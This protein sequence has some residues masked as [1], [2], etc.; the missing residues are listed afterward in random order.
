MCALAGAIF[1]K[2]LGKRKKSI[3]VANEQKA[4]GHLHLSKNGHH[5]LLSFGELSAVQL[6]HLP[7]VGLG[8]G[9][10][11]VDQLQALLLGKVI[12]IGLPLARDPS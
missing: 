4:M 10:G 3:G 6:L 1:A 11:L 2:G 9:L 5:L 12:S 8:L 7:L